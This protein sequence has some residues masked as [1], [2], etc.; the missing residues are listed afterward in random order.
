MCPEPPG[1]LRWTQ[2]AP[3]LA[4][5]RD[6][7]SRILPVEHFLPEIFPQALQFEK[8]NSLR[9]SHGFAK[10]LHDLLRNGPPVFAGPTLDRAIK[11]VGEILDVQ[12][13]HRLP[14]EWRNDTLAASISQIW[15]LVRP[16]GFEPTTYSSG[17]LSLQLRQ[18]NIMLF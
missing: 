13:G 5:F 11:T 6:V 18:R 12:R 4:L 3:R 16:V 9:Y 15:R 2:S 10:K 7:I 1:R 8:R 17:R 14:P